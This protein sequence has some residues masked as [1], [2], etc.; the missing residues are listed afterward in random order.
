L[1]DVRWLNLERGTWTGEVRR[2]PGGK[3]T[4]TVPFEGEAVL[5]LLSR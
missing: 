1:F 3:T 5:L 2:L 4:F